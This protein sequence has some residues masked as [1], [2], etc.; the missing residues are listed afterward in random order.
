MGPA[1]IARDPCVCELVDQR[2]AR[3][4][5]NSQRSCIAKWNTICSKLSSEYWPSWITVCDTF[6]PPSLAAGCRL[7]LPTSLSDAF[8]VLPLPTGL[9]TQLNLGTLTEA[10]ILS[11][12]AHHSRA[13]LARCIETA[14]SFAEQRSMVVWLVDSPLAVF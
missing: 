9:L 14:A 2:P 12:T 13:N 1:F 11:I 4:R 5:K 3:A 10:P 8:A 6:Q 7:L